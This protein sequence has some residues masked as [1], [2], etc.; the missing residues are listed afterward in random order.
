MASDSSRLMERSSI[1]SL[2]ETVRG[3]VMHLVKGYEFGPGGS[4]W[5]RT[6]AEWS[7]RSL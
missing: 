7:V 2:H 3:R 5:K 4:D 1:P 6:P